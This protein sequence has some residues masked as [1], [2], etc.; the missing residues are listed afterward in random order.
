MES[1]EKTSKYIVTDSQG[2]FPESPVHC[3]SK[4]PGEITLK[5]CKKQ[6]SK[7]LKIFVYGL[8]ILD[9]YKIPI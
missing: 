6:S 8:K 5:P 1:K 4:V 2:T 7:E 3:M 9:S